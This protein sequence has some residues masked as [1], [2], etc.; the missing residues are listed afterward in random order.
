[1]RGS[2]VNKYFPSV[3]LIA[4]A[5]V[6]LSPSGCPSINLPIPIVQPRYESLYAVVVEETKDR[7][8]YSDVINS[9][10]WED[11]K[12]RKVDYRFY[13]DDSD[14]AKPY[15]GVVT[16]RPALILLTAE[17]SVVWKGPLPKSAADA[18]K[19]IEGYLK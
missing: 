6:F 7:A 12:K 14:E 2:E 5:L 19:F 10:I 17:G 13:D 1:M 11:L 9:P 4:A 3:L 15:T 16:D 8:A 18:K